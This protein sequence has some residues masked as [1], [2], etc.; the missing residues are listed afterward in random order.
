MKPVNFVIRYIQRNSFSKTIIIVIAL[1]FVLTPS[2]AVFAPTAHA[3]TVGFH[4]KPA[5]GNVGRIVVASGT[6][7]LAPANALVSIKFDGKVVATATANGTG[8]FT[9][10]FKAPEAAVGSHTVTAYAGSQQIGLSLVFAVVTHLS[11]TPK[12]ARVNVLVTV[13]GTGYAA[14]SPV[15][16]EFNNAAIAT[17]PASVVTNTTGGFKAVFAVPNVSDNGGAGMAYPVSA[18]DASSNTAIATFIVK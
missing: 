12:M 3:A 6:N 18:M 13:T 16:I 15:T 1:L 5:M 4:I 8:Y 14:S 7:H 10:N 9:T 11:L 2:F 17:S